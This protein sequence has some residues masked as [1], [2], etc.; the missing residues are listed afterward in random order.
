MI[1]Y[2]ELKDISPTKNSTVKTAKLNTYPI[3]NIILKSIHESYEKA[4][5]PQSDWTA[6]YF[7]DDGIYSTI[8]YCP[9]NPRTKPPFMQHMR[10]LCAADGERFSIIDDTYV[11]QTCM[12][13]AIIELVPGDDISRLGE[14][15]NKELA[16]FKASQTPCIVFNETK[17]KEELQ[18]RKKRM[19]ERGEEIPADVPFEVSQFVQ[20]IN[21]PTI[22]RS[23]ENKNKKTFDFVR[24]FIGIPHTWYMKKREFL[25]QN[26]KPIFKMVLEAIKNDKQYQ[27]Y[28]IP[29]NFLKL[30]SCTI[31]CQDEI[32][33]VF[34]LKLQ[35]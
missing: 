21:R 29:I 10:K 27:K 18:N 24:I 26:K 28:N 19:K 33:M 25:I 12:M 5:S 16:K 4:Y 3:T 30:T 9:F 20:K 8:H 23:F 22:E 34:E 1:I 32:E 31:T 6:Y 14:L 17:S 35:E 13:K 15:Y 7:N 11:L 2:D